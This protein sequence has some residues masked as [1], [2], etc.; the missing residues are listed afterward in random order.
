M[1]KAARCIMNNKASNWKVWTRD[2][3]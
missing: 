3:N 1:A 2:I